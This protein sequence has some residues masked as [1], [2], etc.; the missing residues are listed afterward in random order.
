MH[1]TY[2]TGPSLYEIPGPEDEPTR[3]SHDTDVI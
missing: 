3:R 1:R 2:K